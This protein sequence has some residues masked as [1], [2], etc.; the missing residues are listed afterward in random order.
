M[1]EQNIFKSFGKKFIDYQS[2]KNF[3]LMPIYLLYKKKKYLLC[4]TENHNYI[5]KKK[6]YSYFHY[7]DKKYTSNYF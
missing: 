4:T 6:R 1:I 3:N 2:L 7:S 5:H